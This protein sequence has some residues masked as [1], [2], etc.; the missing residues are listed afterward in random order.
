MDGRRMKA[1]LREI[2][3]V[4]NCLS[5]TALY[6]MNLSTANLNG[7]CLQEVGIENAGQARK[8]RLHY[9]ESLNHNVNLVRGGARDYGR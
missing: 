3:S 9:R 1:T 6:E 8:S 2:F 7:Q 5:E 4:R